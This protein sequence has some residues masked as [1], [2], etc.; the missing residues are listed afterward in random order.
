MDNKIYKYIEQNS[1]LENDNKD[2]IQF[3]IQMLQMLSL[4]VMAAFIIGLLM[5]MLPEAFVFLLMLIP[6][7]QSAGG[8]HTKNKAT[9][10]IMS[11]LIYIGVLFFIKNYAINPIIQLLICFIDS[12]VI[13]YFAPV[14][15]LNNKLDKKEIEVYKNRT[16]NILVFELLVY[17]LFFVGNLQYWSGIITMSITVV[18]VLVFIGALQNIIISKR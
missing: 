17:M 16:R 14:E 8:Y 7:R 5:K 12:L 15:N 11:A 1:N 13:M 4:A 9:C 3:G 18:S 6:L 2:V 10:A